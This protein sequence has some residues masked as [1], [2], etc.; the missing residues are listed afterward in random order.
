MRLHS[1]NSD[2]AVVNDSS[3]H[4]RHHDYRQHSN[5]NCYGDG[6]LNDNCIQHT[7][8]DYLQRAN[9]NQRNHH[10]HSFDTDAPAQF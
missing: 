9:N 3:S 8:Y 10:Q 6:G 7:H 4:H 2:D 5:T 1:F